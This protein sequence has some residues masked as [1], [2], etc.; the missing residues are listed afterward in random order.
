VA[1]LRNLGLYW[2]E[3]GAVDDAINYYRRAVD[4]DPHDPWVYLSYGRALRRADMHDSSAVQF[5]M[6][7]QIDP[8]FAPARLNLAEYHKLVG[9]TEEAINHYQ[10]MTRNNP[11]YMTRDIERRLRELI[12]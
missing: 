10:A 5:E 11:T 6:A 1:T 8:F 3:H 4:A 9:N 12:R 2:I 7:L